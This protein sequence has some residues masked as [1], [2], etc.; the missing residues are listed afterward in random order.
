MTRVLLF[1]KAPRAGRVKTR[2]A[3]EIGEAR[4]VEL[5]RAIGRSV[6]TAVAEAYSLTVWFDP[7]DAE[8]E[9]RAWLG[10]HECRPQ[11][12]GDLGERMAFAF[13]EHFA[14]GERPVIGI[15]ADVPG[16]SAP[17]IADAE[18]L[19]EQADVVLGP[20][21]DGGYYLIGLPAPRDALFQRI[22]WGSSRVF[23][24]TEERCEALGMRAARLAPLRDI[25]TREDLDALGSLT[26]GTRLDPLLG[27]TSY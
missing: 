14:S 11:P 7:P 17:V 13:A 26:P 15:G 2:L 22:P 25:D 3:R 21:L 24:A 4:A 12:D 9:M 8:E 27:R 10:D 23:R 6:A 5:Y 16:I 1:A 19:L 18:R 20:A